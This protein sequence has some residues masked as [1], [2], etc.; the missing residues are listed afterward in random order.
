MNLYIITHRYSK[1]PVNQIDARHGFKT[2][3]EFAKA[4][5]NLS[6]RDVRDLRRNRTVTLYN[7]NPAGVRA[8]SRYVEIKKA[9]A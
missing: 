3:L 2:A 7:G 6:E 9:L 8:G 1:C 5:Y 4:E